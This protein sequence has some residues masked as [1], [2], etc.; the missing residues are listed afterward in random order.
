M[1][2]HAEL[3]R[4]GFL[5]DY[6]KRLQA[7]LGDDSKFEDLQVLGRPFLFAGATLCSA[8]FGAL[9]RRERSTQAPLHS[10]VLLE[11]VGWG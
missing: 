2:V 6:V 11:A 3:L 4:I 1:P 5:E 9:I 8:L 10:G 7:A